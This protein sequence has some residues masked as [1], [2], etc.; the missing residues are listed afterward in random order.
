MYLYGYWPINNVK[1]TYL[2]GIKLKES[3]SITYIFFLISTTIKDKGFELGITR[4]D[5]FNHLFYGGILKIFFL[6]GVCFKFIVVK[7]Y[8]ILFNYNKIRV[9]GSYV[10]WSDIRLH[11][12]LIL[13]TN[14][15]TLFVNN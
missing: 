1:F 12:D 7:S 15:T 14:L 10:I 9:W 5:E 2:L 13:K 6:N 4:V 3:S 8:P 11:I